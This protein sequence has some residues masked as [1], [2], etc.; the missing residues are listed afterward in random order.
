LRAIP[1]ARVQSLFATFRREHP[2]CEAPEVLES[3][4]PVAIT[5]RLDCAGSPVNP[6]L[7]TLPTPPYLLDELTIK[8]VAKPRTGF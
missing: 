3:I 5:A 2:A 8:S 6:S 4:S 1:A 7:H